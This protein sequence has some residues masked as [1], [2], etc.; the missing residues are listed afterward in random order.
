[1]LVSFTLS[2]FFPSLKQPFP[3]PFCTATPKQIYFW[4]LGLKDKT[5]RCDSNL[6]SLSKEESQ[7]GRRRNY[8]YRKRGDSSI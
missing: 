5:P 2:F 6:I 8:L 3:S 7:R 4:P 1:M